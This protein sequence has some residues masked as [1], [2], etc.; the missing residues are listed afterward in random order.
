M[1]MIVRTIKK[2]V[3]NWLMLE[4]SDEVKLLEKQW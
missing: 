2:L 3:N 1:K 4:D